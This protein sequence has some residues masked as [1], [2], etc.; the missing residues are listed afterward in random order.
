MD[1]LDAKF[2]EMGHAEDVR[3]EDAIEQQAPCMATATESDL[4]EANRR[5]GLLTE[6]LLQTQLNLQAQQVAASQRAATAYEDDAAD[7]WI[8]FIAEQ[9]DLPA[10]GTPA[11]MELRSMQQ[12]A[13][14]F[15]AIPWG[16]LPPPVQFGM[17]DAAPSFVRSL[18][19][20][21][22]WRACWLDRADFITAQHWVPVKLLNIL[23]L[24]VLQF[25]E[26]LVPAQLEVGKKR[27]ME[28]EDEATKRRPG[29]YGPECSSIA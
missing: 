12:L 25:K 3:F 2:V 29:P 6:Q 22:I 20:D 15:A 13:A 7:L 11:P 5:C 4:D 16:T 26:S 1:M 17:I 27:F 28:V 9:I 23:I 21:T 14:I 10:L 19:G 8:E 18:V 24:V